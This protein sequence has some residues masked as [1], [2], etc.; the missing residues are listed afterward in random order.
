[1]LCA[2]A[3]EPKKKYQVIARGQELKGRTD[4]TQGAWRKFRDGRTVLYLDCSCGYIIAYISKLTKYKLK[5][6]NLTVYKL[7]LNRKKKLLGDSKTLFKKDYKHIKIV[8]EAFT[9]LLFDKKK[10]P[11]Y[12]YP[13]IQ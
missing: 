6:V 8:I 10:K 5:R 9:I 1:M 11:N 7:Y 12:N 4:Y 3:P 2:K 13:L